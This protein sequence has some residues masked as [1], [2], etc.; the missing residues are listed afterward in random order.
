MRSRPE[1]IGKTDNSPVPPR[2]KL[3]IIER[4]DNKCALTGRIFRPGDKIEFD[5]KTALFLHG[6]HRENNLQAVLAEAHQNKTRAQAHI[7]AKIMRVCKKH[8]GLKP[9]RQW[10]SSHLKKKINGEV[11]KRNDG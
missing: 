10:P 5:H 3:R 9:K 4:Q 7:K 8:L 11:V 2:V 6:E 1:W